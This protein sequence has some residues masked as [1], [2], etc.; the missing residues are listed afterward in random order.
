M[1]AGAASL[2]AGNRAWMCLIC[3]F[4]YFEA[5]GLPDEGIP[6]G[7]P[8]EAVP[9]TW[10]CPTCGTAKTDFVMELL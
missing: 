6:P 5:Q 8:W 3:G 9:D 4:V 10:T 1:S 7:T 2:P